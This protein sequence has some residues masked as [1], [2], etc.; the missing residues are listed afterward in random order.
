MQANFKRTCIPRGPPTTTHVQ[1]GRKDPPIARPAGS[2]SHHEVQVC[3]GDIGEKGL[4]TMRNST[5]D[6]RVEGDK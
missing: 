3:G 5:G 4:S 6:A 1:A 2:R